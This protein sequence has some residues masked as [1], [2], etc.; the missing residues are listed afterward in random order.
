MPTLEITL[1]L[2]DLQNLTFFPLKDREHS[3]NQCGLVEAGMKAP[4]KGSELLVAKK[5]TRLYG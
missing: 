4:G 2:V 5:T 1:N 3:H